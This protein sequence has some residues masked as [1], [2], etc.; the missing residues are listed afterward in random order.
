MPVSL[1]IH[2]CL[3]AIPLMLMRLVDGIVLTNPLVYKSVYQKAT[4][5][6]GGSIQINMTGIPTIAEPKFYQNI[7]G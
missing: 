2:V 5:L 1:I 7:Q 3:N 4:F 6:S